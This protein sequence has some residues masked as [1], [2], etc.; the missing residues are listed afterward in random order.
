MLCYA[1]SYSSDANGL[2]T[3]ECEC[4]CERVYFIAESLSF[5]VQI[6]YECYEV[7]K[8]KSLD[9]MVTFG[10]CLEF[11]WK[12]FVSYERKI[13]YQENSLLKFFYDAIRRGRKT[14]QF[15]GG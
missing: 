5:I 6:T 9:N 7:L 10:K 11:I 15:D 8:L 2:V 3:C 4:E 14:C 1:L 12:G 13:G